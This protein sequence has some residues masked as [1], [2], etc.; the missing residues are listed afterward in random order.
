MGIAL[1]GEGTIVFKGAVGQ[2]YAIISKLCSRARE[3]FFYRGRG[4][5]VQAVGAVYH[6]T[7]GT[8]PVGVINIQ[9]DGSGKI[10]ELRRAD[11]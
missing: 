5:D 1:G 7:A 9:G 10:G 6:I 2:Q 4:H 3:E 11:A 8:A